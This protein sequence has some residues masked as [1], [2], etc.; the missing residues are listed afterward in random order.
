MVKWDGPYKKYY[1]NGQLQIDSFK[2]DD[3]W[4]GPYKKYYENGQ[5]RVDSA[6]KDDKWDGPYKNTMRTAN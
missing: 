1:E 3:K 4:D 5:L 2:K 6:H